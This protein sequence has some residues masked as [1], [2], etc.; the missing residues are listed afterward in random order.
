MIKKEDTD[1]EECITEWNKIISEK[2]SQAIVRSEVKD[3]QVAELLEQLKSENKKYEDLEFPTVL[4][5]IT[6]TKNCKN[7]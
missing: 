3:S 4:S 2:R 6:R 1:D 5:S 7:Y